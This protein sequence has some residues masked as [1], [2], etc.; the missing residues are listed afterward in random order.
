MNYIKFNYFDLLFYT[1]TTILLFFVLFLKI[2]LPL[3]IKNDKVYDI[4]KKNKYWKN[5][6]NIIIKEKYTTTKIPKCNCNDEKKIISNLEDLNKSVNSEM[7]SLKNKYQDL[8]NRYFIA[9]QTT[10]TDTNLNKNNNN[11]ILTT[12]NH[13]NNFSVTENY[14]FKEDKDILKTFKKT[15]K[16]KYEFEY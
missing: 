7:F 13:E 10:Q 15:N 1:I 16:K 3:I 5:L 14:F 9:K 12:T 8:E 4:L 2:L 6:F 11:D